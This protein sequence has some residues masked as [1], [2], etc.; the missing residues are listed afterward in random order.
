MR[1]APRYFAL[2]AD[3]PTSI[4]TLGHD[5]L[6]MFLWLL[7]MTAWPH[8]VL[9]KPQVQPAGSPPLA[10]T[11]AQSNLYPCAYTFHL[12]SLMKKGNEP[13]CCGTFI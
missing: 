8:C 2:A 10:R 9:P 3:P 13:V 7:Q 12:P 5:C 1:R 11:D 6:L 4:V